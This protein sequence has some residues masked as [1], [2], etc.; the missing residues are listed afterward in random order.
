M[1][2]SVKAERISGRRLPLSNNQ[3]IYDCHHISFLKKTIAFRITLKRLSQVTVVRNWLSHQSDA[4]QIA[5]PVERYGSAQ[6]RMDDH[7]CR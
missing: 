2:T 5:Y 4:S 7:L 6:I 1:A 3:P